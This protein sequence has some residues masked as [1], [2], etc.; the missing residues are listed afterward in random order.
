MEG[1]KRKIELICPVCQAKNIIEIPEKIFAQKQFGSIKIQVPPGAVCPDHQFIVFLDTKGLVRGYEKIDIL[2]GAPVE[3]AEKKEI[4]EGKLT[5]NQLINI[6][7]LYGVF[8]LIHSKL[9]GFHAY[10]IRENSS[11]EFE[12]QINNFLNR[13]TENQY[14]N[15]KKIEFI[16]DTD[17]N[18]I[19]LK[20]KNA[21]LIDAHNNIMQTPWEEKLTFEESLVKSALEIINPEEQIVLIKRNVLNFIKEVNYT[22]KILEDVK[23]IYDT[24]LIDLIKRDLKVS[25]INKTRLN[26]I[27]SFIIRNISEEL[28]DKIQNKVQ[29][30]LSSL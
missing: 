11:E 21:L 5:L 4:S 22:I 23:E 3:K 28:G 9:F 7:G 30:F 18:Q 20:N 14:N 8:S 17:Y 27:K 10:I 24:D 2:M 1:A 19:N 13:I 26:L 15:S 16:D 25:K 29:E 12:D 6:F